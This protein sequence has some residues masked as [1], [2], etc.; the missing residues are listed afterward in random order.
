M[1]GAKIYIDFTKY[2]FEECSSRL[3]KELK[4]YTS[5]IKDIITKADVNPSNQLIKKVKSS[6]IEREAI[7]EKKTE[8]KI[9]AIGWTQEQALAWFKSKCIKDSIMEALMPI[10][11]ILLD[12][13]NRTL[14]EVP[15]FFHSILHKDSN[16][17]LRDIVVFTN[18]LR[19]IFEEPI[20]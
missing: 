6:P 2:E 1:L 17:S 19:S 8:N 18:E 7:Q 4:N 9:K 14:K 20:D 16:A 13:L 10:D 11:G 12:Q 3:V 15:E 5:M